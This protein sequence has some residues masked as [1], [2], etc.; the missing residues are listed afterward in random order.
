MGKSN[1]T[2]R[3]CACGRLVAGPRATTCHVPSKCGFAAAALH[4]RK[5]EAA[6]IRQERA[7]NA[8]LIG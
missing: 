3:F 7:E 2:V 8:G 1:K 5:Q 6:Q 4:Q